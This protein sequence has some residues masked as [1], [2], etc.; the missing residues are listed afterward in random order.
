MFVC[1]NVS[2]FRGVEEIREAFQKGY[3]C[4]G[5]SESDIFLC[6]VEEKGPYNVVVL[7]G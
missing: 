2:C 5:W 3:T 7:L 6:S 1:F 4:G